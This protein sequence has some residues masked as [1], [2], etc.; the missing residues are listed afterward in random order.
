M[1]H[2]KHEYKAGDKFTF[3]GL[4][5]FPIDKPFVVEAKPCTRQWCEG[6]FFWDWNKELCRDDDGLFLCSGH[7]RKD[8]KF[9]YFVKEGKGESEE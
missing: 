7:Q 1:K 5:T 9:V 8:M 3:Y 6:C 4:P 2:E